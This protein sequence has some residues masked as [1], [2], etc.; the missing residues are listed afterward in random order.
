ME[1][2]SF[3]IRIGNRGWLRRGNTPE[4]AIVHVLKVM[5][6]TARSGG[7]RG[8]D[9]FGLRGFFAQIGQRRG[10][11][12][13]VIKLMNR[14]LVN[15]GIEWFRIESVVKEDSNDVAKASYAVTVSFAGKESNVVRIET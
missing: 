14:T 10:L 5:A 6:L 9:E 4:E 7:W 8:A 3:P 12:P 13:D 2:I 11:E 1:F 15:L